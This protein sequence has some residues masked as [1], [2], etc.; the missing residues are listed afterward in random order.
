[1][2]KVT[3]TLESKK[4]HSKSIRRQLGLKNA[5]HLDDDTKV[6]REQVLPLDDGRTWLAEKPRFN[7]YVSP[8][9]AA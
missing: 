6:S 5:L 4:G 9:V 3:L 7:M 1:M 2:A 8:R